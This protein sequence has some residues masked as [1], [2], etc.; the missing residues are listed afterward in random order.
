MMADKDLADDADAW[1]EGR[2]NR[3][4]RTGHVSKNEVNLRTLTH[5]NAAHVAQV[6][7]PPRS[8]EMD[9][10]ILEKG[11]VAA[12]LLMQATRGL[13]DLKFAEAAAPI[14]N[15]IEAIK[16]CIMMTSLEHQKAMQK[17]LLGSYAEFC[18]ASTEYLLLKQCNQI[19]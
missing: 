1:L 9:Q 18:D 2:K 12:I 6:T 16:A 8:E 7:L 17:I 13:V 14:A 10:A 5:K 15:I 19:V 3:K 4:G 11:E